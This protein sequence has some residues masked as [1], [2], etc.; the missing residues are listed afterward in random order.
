MAQTDCYA[1]WRSAFLHCSMLCGLSCDTM[2]P[3]CV[4]LPIAV[5]AQ[6][7]EAQ[8]TLQGELTT[9]Q[10]QHAALQASTETGQVCACAALVSAQLAAT[11]CS[12]SMALLHV[13]CLLNALPI[14]WIC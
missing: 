7:T 12:H 1:K 5:Q 10:E 13:D 9:L 11:W 3:S 14:P 6:M 4:L 2:S 8:A